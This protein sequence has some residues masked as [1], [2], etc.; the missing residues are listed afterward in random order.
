MKRRDSPG[1]PFLKIPLVSIEYSFFRNTHLKVIKIGLFGQIGVDDCLRM[2]GTISMYYPFL[3]QPVRKLLDSLMNSSTDL[4]E[5]MG[6]LRSVVSKADAAESLVHIAAFLAYYLDD[7]DMTHTIATEH[8]NLLSAKPWAL[9]ERDSMHAENHDQLIAIDKLLTSD[10]EDW[11]ALKAHLLKAAILYLVPQSYDSLQSAGEILDANPK[12]D[13]FRDWYYLTQ[14][15][16][17]R[18]E[19]DIELVSLLREKALNKSREY[20]DPVSEIAILMQQTEF[21]MNVDV[22]RAMEFT[23]RAYEL[24]EELGMANLKIKAV[25]GVG[26][27]STVLGEYD[28]ALHSWIESVEDL[29]KR[30]IPECHSY[31]RIAQL[32][33]DLGDGMNAFEW[34]RMAMEVDEKAAKYGGLDDHIC[35]NVAM[36]HAAI[37]AN[38]LDEAETYIEKSHEI[39]LRSGQELLLSMYYYIQGLYEITLG[40]ASSG[41]DTLARALEICD[42]TGGHPAHMNRCLIGLTKAEIDLFDTQVRS[43]TDPSDS[44]PHMARLEN[45]SRKRGMQGIQMQHALLKAKFQEKL[46]KTDLAME[47]LEYALST[48]DS[49]GVRTLRNQ[50]L[51]KIRDIKERPLSP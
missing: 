49:P 11:I 44:G 2:I 12:L 15:L 10:P 16:L 4:H 26:M 21:M 3:P 41:Q 43:D 7:I 45:E 24:A 22:A 25:Q 50:I 19:G 14:I 20:D 36:A 51:D 31:I 1:P 30:G 34:A 48:H 46:G 39:A 18:Y 13:C 47:T 28:L 27:V 17:R 23:Q 37:V 6:R 42:R 33:A 32:Y 9:L 29:Q 38:K 35:P 8:R 40:D 5:F